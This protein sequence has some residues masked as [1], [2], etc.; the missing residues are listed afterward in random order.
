MQRRWCRPGAGTGAKM[1]RY[2]VAEVMQRF[3]GPDVLRGCSCLAD[4]VLRCSIT[5]EVPSS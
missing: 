2:R 5:E 3:R 1:Q 4:V